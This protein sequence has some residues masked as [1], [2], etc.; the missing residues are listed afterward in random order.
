MPTYWEII[1][2]PAMLMPIPKES[3]TKITGQMKLIAPRALSPSAK[4]LTQYMSVTWYMVW[5]T[6]PSMMGRDRE[7]RTLD[8]LPDKIASRF[9]VTFMIILL[10][11][12]LS[13]AYRK[14]FLRAITEKDL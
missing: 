12:Y 6:L 7:S 9:L 8:M 13:L 5:M 11:V 4:R 10:S 1:L 2:V 14:V 3:I